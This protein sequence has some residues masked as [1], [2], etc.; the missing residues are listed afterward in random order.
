[1]KKSRIKFSPEEKWLRKNLG[2]LVKDRGGEFVVVAGEEGFVSVSLKKALAQAKKKY[3]KT[4]P[5]IMEI[6]EEKD[7]LHVLIFF[8]LHHS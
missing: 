3:P 2:K 1:M 8:S 7:F 5:L 4:Q 6:P